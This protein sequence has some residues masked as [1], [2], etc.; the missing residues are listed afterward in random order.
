MSATYRRTDPPF[1]L[2]NLQNTVDVAQ[3]IQR[4]EEQRYFAIFVKILFKILDD[5][6]PSLC[7]YAKQVSYIFVVEAV[8]ATSYHII[9]P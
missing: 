7:M 9:Y 3:A 6:D 8:A 2:G 5:K 1:P 4:K